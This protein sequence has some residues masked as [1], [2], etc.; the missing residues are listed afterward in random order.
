MKTLNLIALLLFIA[1]SVAVFMLDTPTTRTVQSKVMA[2]FAPFMHAS[3]TVENTTSRA[4]AEDID[5]KE[6][7]RETEA[8]RL[9][10]QKL[11]ILSQRHDELLEENNKLRNMIGYRERSPFKDLIACRVIKRSAATWWSTLIIDKGSA[12]GV[13]P[14]RAVL[15]DVGLVGK[16]GKVSPHVSEV[17]LLTDELCRV[18]AVIDGTR[19]KGILSGER[20]SLENTPDLRLRFLSRNAPIAP[21]TNVISS[22]DGGVFPSGLLLGR[23][24]LFEN[25]DISGEALVE[26]AVDF[27]KLEDVF[28]VGSSATPP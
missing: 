19:E 21:G 14:D 1:A 13:A 24:K 9:K 8:L 15:T 28:V 10:V 18:A 22:G 16:T 6:L 7:L 11:T 26:T 17:I 20:G 23:V 12:D 3:A 25:K 5:P 27:T 2:I 4:I